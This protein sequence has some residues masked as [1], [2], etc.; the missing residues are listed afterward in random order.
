MAAA[1]TVRAEAV[2]VEAEQVTRPQGFLAAVGERVAAAAALVAAKATAGRAGAGA[3]T[4]AVMAAAGRA[5]AGVA[6]AAAVVDNL[7][8]SHNRAKFGTS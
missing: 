5:R 4:A 6:M 2:T 7:W 8:S 1:E 3:A